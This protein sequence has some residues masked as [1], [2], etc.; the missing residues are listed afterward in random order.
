MRQHGKGLAEMYANTCRIVGPS[1]IREV[2]EGEMKYFVLDDSMLEVE[3]ER[4]E[5]EMAAW[6]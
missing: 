2:D 4:I 6:S 3:W 1:N 5:R